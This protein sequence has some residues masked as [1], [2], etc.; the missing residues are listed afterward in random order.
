ML[1][2][3]VPDMLI[4]SEAQISAMGYCWLLSDFYIPHKRGEKHYRL[5]AFLKLTVGVILIITGVYKIVLANLNVFTCLC[6]IIG[7]VLIFINAKN[8]FG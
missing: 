1:G 8:T 7:T 6:F 4:S 5:L 2:F 3:N